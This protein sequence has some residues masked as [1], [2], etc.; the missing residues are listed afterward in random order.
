MGAGLAFVANQL[1]PQGLRL[2]R[3]YF[4]AVPVQH[5]AVSKQDGTNSAVERI[6]QRG[7]GFIDLA[8]AAQLFHSPE[9]QQK[10]VLFV[11]ARDDEHYKAGHIPGAYQL[12]YYQ[13]E[14]YLPALLPLTQVAEK[15]VVY[16]NGGDCEDSELTAVLLQ[17]T[18]VSPQKISVYGGGFN[19]WK[20]K[21]MPVATGERLSGES[22]PPPK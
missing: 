6:R 13:P 18:G 7:F 8:Q 16:C 17:N 10:T 2:S 22:Q 21:G 14:P 5:N 19:E 1:S 20:T 9:Y 4:S 11:D 15:I 3:D 12:Y